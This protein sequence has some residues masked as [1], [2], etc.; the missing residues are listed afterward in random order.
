MLASLLTEDALDLELVWLLACS[1]PSPFRSRGLSYTLPLAD[2]AGGS[3]VRRLSAKPASESHIVPEYRVC[4][5]HC[6]ATDQSAITSCSTAVLTTSCRVSMYS[7]RASC[8]LSAPSRSTSFTQ[9]KLTH[10]ER[11]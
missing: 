9:S 4:I 7:V 8:C 3:G 11:P 5:C 10:M 6:I 2:Q 1:F